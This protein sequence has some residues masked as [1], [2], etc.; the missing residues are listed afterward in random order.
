VVSRLLSSFSFRPDPFFCVASPSCVRFFSPPTFL[1]PQYK[2]TKVFLEGLIAS[3]GSRIVLVAN[4]EGVDKYAPCSPGGGLLGCISLPDQ[5]VNT[6][7][8]EARR[9]ALLSEMLDWV[10]KVPPGTLFIMCGGPLSKALISVA[11]DNA[12]VHQYVDFGSS[13][14]EVLKGRTTRPYMRDGTSYAQAIDPQWYCDPPNTL[15]P[16]GNC[17]T[18]GPNDP[19][20]KWNQP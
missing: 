10:K 14:D 8:D 20:L 16:E 15:G 11:W 6:W 7:E 1:P 13:M 9:T 18:L 19:E 4:H 3:Q 12:P 5:A 2:H 17:G